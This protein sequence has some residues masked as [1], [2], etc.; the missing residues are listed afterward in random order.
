MNDIH[1]NVEC[2]KALSVVLEAGQS[3]SEFAFSLDYTSVPLAVTVVPLKELRG[4]DGVI[5]SLTERAL[6]SGD[7]L[8]A[9]QAKIQ[10]GDNLAYHTMVTTP[11]LK[12]IPVWF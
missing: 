12:R 7:Q 2:K 10:R 6:Q 8:M 4:D 5:A 11:P 3:P 9:V 1:E